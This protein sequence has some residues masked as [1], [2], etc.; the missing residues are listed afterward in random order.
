MV[1]F[2]R[3]LPSLAVVGF[4]L[5]FSAC[6]QP[7]DNTLPDSS[8]LG[9]PRGYRLIRTITHFHSPYSWDACDKNG[10]IGGKVNAVCLQHL[11]DALCSNRVDLIF[12]TDHPDSMQNFEMRDL[13]LVS[14]KD[15]VVLKNGNPYANKM[16]GCSNSFTPE[17]L[18]GFEDRLLALGMT[19]H[20]DPNLAIRSDLYHQETVDLR[21]RLATQAEAVVLIPHT[22]SRS[23]ETIRT[24]QPDGIEIYSFHANIDP[25][26]RVDSL[27]APPFKNIPGFLTYLVDPYREL[28]PDFS[29]LNFIETFPVYF[30]TWNSLI[31]GGLRVSGFGG[32]DS[33]ENVFPQIASDDERLDSHRRVMRIMS[34]HLL[35]MNVDPDEA[36]QAIKNGQGWMVFEGLGSPVGM[37]FYATFGSTTV[38]VGQTGALA[39]ATAT[40]T[41][42]LPSLY[43][44]SPH[45]AD[46]PIVGL[47]LK[48]VLAGGKDKVVASAEGKDIQYQTNVAGA[49]RAEVTI[50]PKHLRDLLGSFSSQADKEFTWIITNHLYLD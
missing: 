39:G 47:T 24:L 42:K 32:T 17:V 21:N 6:K 8:K 29:F 43:S 9:S 15:E 41:V 16:Q 1:Y 44:G 18:T 49:Y 12:L 35:V 34:N 48:Q 2:L 19:G 23:L 33:H 20:L 14:G 50:V 30:E 3:S 25:K 45:G 31:A 28:N 13:L 36:K 26:I 5:S 22:E 10:L 37:D 11:R 40:I 7:Y 38:G 46:A 27:H 4:F